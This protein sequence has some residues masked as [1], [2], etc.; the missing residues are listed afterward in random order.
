MPFL[1]SFI[2]L[3]SVVG[4]GA[5]TYTVANDIDP[6]QVSGRAARQPVLCRSEESPLVTVPCAIPPRRHRRVQ[7]QQGLYMAPV[8]WHPGPPP[9]GI[10]FEGG[11]PLSPAS[12][13]DDEAPPSGSTWQHPG[14]VQPPV[15]DE[16]TTP[17]PSN[18]LANDFSVTDT[19]HFGSPVLL[20]RA[21]VDYYSARC[22][23][24]A[25]LAI[26]PE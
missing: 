2:L 4:V 10:L 15:I 21:T 19:L 5:A 24:G 6:V 20:R 23:D 1:L 9:P 17:T 3:I 25:P 12:S 18:S 16:S 14:A 26:D 7:R 13:S 8:P 22:G 11:P